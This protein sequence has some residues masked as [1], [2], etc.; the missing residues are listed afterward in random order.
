MVQ[1]DEID[2][3]IV[4]G[5]AISS[6]GIKMFQLIS[7]SRARSLIF[8]FLQKIERGTLKIEIAKPDGTPGETFRFGE[9]ARNRRGPEVALLVKN[10]QFWKRVCSNMD[11]VS[12][13]LIIQ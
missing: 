5:R 13:R 10:P 11:L 4:L 9:D 7:P 12:L 1:K 2:N 3:L 8:R 6:A